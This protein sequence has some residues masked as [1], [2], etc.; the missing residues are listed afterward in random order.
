M[1][2]HEEEVLGKAYDSR[3]MA[4][5]LGYLAPYKLTVAA[6]FVLILAISGLKLVGP[7]L[8]KVAI[9][10]YIAND[11]LAGLNLVALLYVLALLAEFVLSYLQTYIMNLTGQRIMFDMRREIFAHIQRLHPAFFDKNPVGRILTRVTTDVDALNELFTAGVVTVFGDIFMLL[12]IMIVLIMLN[13]K[14]ALVSFAVL[15]ALFVVSLIFKRKVRESYR[16]VRTRIARMNAFIQENITGMQV[17]QLFRQEPRKL[18]EF[19]TL[20]REH[21]EANL[22]SIFYYAFFYPVVQLLGAVA[23]AL[24]IW[25]GGGRV[26]AG[27]LTLGALVAFIQYSEKFYRPISDLTEKFNILQSAMA[28]SE[29]IFGLLDRKPMIVGS[30]RQSVADAKQSMEAGRIRFEG[31]WFS[32]QGEEWVLKDV[33]LDIKPGERIAVVGHTGAGKTTLTSLL[34]RFYDVQKGRILLD[35]RDIRGWRLSDLRKQFGIVLQD[36]H[37]FSGS[38]GSN[39]RLGTNTIDDE[40]VAKAASTVHLDRLVNQLPNGFDEE[41]G[42][43]GANLSAGQ[44]QLISFARALAHDP[45]V[46]ILDEATSSVD[47]ETEILIREALDRLMIG[48]TSIVIAHRLSTIQSADRI[49]VMHKGRI[50]EIG[51]HQELLAERGIYYRLYQ[52]QYQEQEATIP[53]L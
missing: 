12:G 33:D 7:Y 16:R 9:D 49:V 28:S 1:S 31:V 27:T 46:L 13:W 2:Y 25:Y 51:S 24:I 48:R 14:L 43:R 15:P 21:M 44:K 30:V 37:L 10:E 38:I 17:V 11:D 53:Q 19:D 4:R 6:A 35:G 32:Y 47:T 42:E 34:L 41:V 20:N 23:I 5:L 45:R 3:L 40:L 50:R 29:R 18:G 8:T 26:M 22:Q 52:L 39:I 36:V